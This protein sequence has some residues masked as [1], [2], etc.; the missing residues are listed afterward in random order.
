[1]TRYP[2]PRFP[3]FYARRAPVASARDSAFRLGDAF[4]SSPRAASLPMSAA[5]SNCVQPMR[6]PPGRQAIPRTPGGHPSVFPVAKIFQDSDRHFELP[7][8]LTTVPA[9]LF[10]LA[11]QRAQP[12]LNT[13][14][15]AASPVALGIEHGWSIARR[16]RRGIALSGCP[17]SNRSSCCKAQR[18]LQPTA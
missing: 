9:H 16:F 4:N 7:V 17:L 13:R 14:F 6:C 8:S 12:G 2:P 18:A 5:S 10:K 15:P 11:Q 1:M 3:P